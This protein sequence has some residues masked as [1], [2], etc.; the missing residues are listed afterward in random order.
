MY[1]TIIF[2]MDGTL[3]STLED[4]C[5][6]VNYALQ[7]HNM[8]PRTLEEV[9]R[10]VGNGAKQLIKLAVPEGTSEEL[11]TSCYSTYEQHYSQNMQN[12]TRP[13]EGIIPLLE[14]LSKRGIKMAIVSNKFDHAV[15]ALCKDYFADYIQLAIGESEF[16]RKKPSPDGVFAALKQLNSKA[17]DSLYIGDSEVDV[18]TAKN[19]GTTCVGVTW[20]F[21]SRKLLEEQGADY[22]I[23]S[24]LELLDLIK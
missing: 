2:D 22:I 4:I 20:G 16:V 13:Y 8:P 17:V 15:K 5:D 1:N 14:E 9:R 19:A 7:S 21:R 24:P 6:N 3:L 11:I 12:K 10:F 18:K 23:D